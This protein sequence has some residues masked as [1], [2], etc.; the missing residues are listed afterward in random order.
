MFP[1]LNLSNF[2]IKWRDALVNSQEI[3]D[4]CQSKYGK[5]LKLFI[6]LDVN[7]PPT[8]QDC[9]YILIYPGKKVEGASKKINRYTIPIEWSIN[10]N[11]KTES[12]NLIELPGGY[13]VEELGQLVLMVLNGASVDH[14]IS[15]VDYN[16]EITESFPQF[17]RRMEVKFHF[18]PALGGSLVY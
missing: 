10:N 3:D 18:I 7:Q 13:E 11:T 16:A 8:K 6:G 4:F 2:I 12:N 1:S 14:P 5:S 9:P 17:I 15:K